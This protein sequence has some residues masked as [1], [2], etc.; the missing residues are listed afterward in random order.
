MRRYWWSGC[1]RYSRFTSVQSKIGYLFTSD[2]SSWWESVAQSL[3]ENDLNKLQH[4]FLH[5]FEITHSFFGGWCCCHLNEWFP[6]NF[7]VWIRKRWHTH[8]H[9]SISFMPLSLMH[10]AYTPTQTLSRQFSN[11]KKKQPKW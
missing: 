9:T 10:F 11:K 8:T 3:D 7:H 6:F 1:W 2:T 4:D 5:S